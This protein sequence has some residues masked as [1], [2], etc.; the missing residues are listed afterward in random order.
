MTALRRTTA[1]ALLAALAACVSVGSAD[2]PAPTDG[3]A[4]PATVTVALTHASLGDR[5]WDN[6]VFWWHTGRVVASL[7]DQPGHLSRMLRADVL[8]GE[9]WTV[10]VWRSP[11]DLDAFVRGPVHR[12]AIE[13]GYGAVA[14][15]EFARFDL[16]AGD[17]PL[18]WDRVEALMAERGR[19]AKYDPRILSGAP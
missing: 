18:T 7:G 15:A 14:L 17:L 19:T 3:T 8:A 5:T 13:A 9:A 4:P 10:T 16:P 12:R 2:R 1:V 6:L 11:A